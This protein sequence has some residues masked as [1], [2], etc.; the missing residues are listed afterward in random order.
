MHSWAHADQDRVEIYEAEVSYFAPRQHALCMDL[1]L[2]LRLIILHMYF[3]KILIA[4]PWVFNRATPACTGEDCCSM[5]ENDMKQSRLTLEA[6]ETL[7]GK[8][9]IWHLDGKLNWALVSPV[10]CRQA[11]S[12]NSSEKWKSFDMHD[13]RDPR[14]VKNCDTNSPTART[15]VQICSCTNNEPRGALHTK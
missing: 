12:R 8:G 5:K 3:H 2:G 9:P 11:W 13:D 7:L 10:F 1:S 15:Q 4:L 6:L 14:E